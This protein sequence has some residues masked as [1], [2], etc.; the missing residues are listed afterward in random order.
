MEGL[1]TELARES[2]EF[3][4]TPSCLVSDFRDLNKYPPLD[5]PFKVF[6]AGCQEHGLSVAAK[7]ARDAIYEL[8]RANLTIGELRYYCKHCIETLTIEMESHLF[9]AIEKDKEYLARDNKP[10]GDAALVAFPEAAYDIEEAAKC[11]VFERWTAAVFHLG[12]AAEIATVT[13]A[14]KAG[15]QD[16]AESFA[17]ALKHIDEG[18]AMLQRDWQNADPLFKGK[19]QFFSEISV[20]MH[21]VNDARRNPVSHM[22]TKYTN[23][24]LNPWSYG[25]R[26]SIATA[27]S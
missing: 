4:D 15:Y 16:W 14:K 27:F 7:S 13:F 9:F 5:L 10:F 19:K 20:H 18:L 24:T 12:R 21:A 11:L 22:D 3:I 1:A 17:K 26:N 23:A 8:R 2:N 6:E 25:L